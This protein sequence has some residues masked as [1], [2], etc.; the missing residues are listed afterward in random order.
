MLQC[1]ASQAGSFRI[2]SCFS[3]SFVCLLRIGAFSVWIWVFIFTIFCRVW[4]SGLHM[5]STKFRLMWS[6][7]ERKR[8]SG[9]TL[10]VWLHTDCIV[11]QNRFKVTRRCA[12]CPFL[13][14]HQT[15]TNTETMINGNV[16]IVGATCAMHILYWPNDDNN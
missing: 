13:S 12:P 2:F 10:F 9:S 3:F 7:T 16:H 11:A 14:I 5:L 8:C 6:E 4:C 15:V 1:A